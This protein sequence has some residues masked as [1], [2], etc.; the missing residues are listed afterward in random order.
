MRRS[1]V[2]GLLLAAA[3][4]LLI[5]VS[6]PL[7]LNVEQFA[8]IGVLIGAVLGLMTDIAVW[9]RLA[10]FGIGLVAAWVTY[11]LRAGFLPDS[12]GG[13]AVAVVGLLAFLVLIVWLVGGRLHLVP[14]LIGVTALAGAYELTFIDAPPRF[15]EE[16]SV[17]V[18]GV[19]LAA[20]VGFACTVLASSLIGPDRVPAGRHREDDGDGDDTEAEVPFDEMFYRDQ[21]VRP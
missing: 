2:A 9:D 20:A 21:E 10:G 19:L 13:R 5:L 8:L 7:S 3:T 11:G 1:I 6:D 18:T 12:S 4:G 14:M 16:S 17:A 15:L